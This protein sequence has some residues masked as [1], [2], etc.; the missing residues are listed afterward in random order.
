MICNED[1]QWHRA[2]LRDLVTAPKTSTQFARSP[3]SFRQAPGCYEQNTN[4]PESRLLDRGLLSNRIIEAGGEIG[5]FSITLE[6]YRRREV[7]WNREHEV[8]DR[9]DEA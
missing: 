6:E 7:D 3:R 4:V 8:A 2:G 1:R 9:G 5:A